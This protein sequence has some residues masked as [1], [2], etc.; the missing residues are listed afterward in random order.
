[1]ASSKPNA[2]VIAAILA[3]EGVENAAYLAVKIADTFDPS[4]SRVVAMR[5]ALQEIATGE[6]VGEPANYRDTLAIVR[7]VA[8]NALEPPNPLPNR[9]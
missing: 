1:M 9:A 6:I 7:D 2:D 8:R 4:P 5:N 3:E